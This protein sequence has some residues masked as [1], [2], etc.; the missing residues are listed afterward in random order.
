MRLWEPPYSRQDGSSS[1]TDE[2]VRTYAAKVCNDC[3]LFV[4]EA[5]PAP[6]ARCGM[7]GVSTCH[8]PCPWIV[9][10]PGLPASPPPVSTH[11][12]THTRARAP[13]LCITYRANSCSLVSAQAEADPDAVATAL[14]ILRVSARKKL[15]L[16]SD[17][18]ESSNA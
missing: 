9:R 10:H 1:I 15:T 11:T 17:G 8:A 12:H 18:P 16:P 4:S 6:C 14:E 5:L 2:V 13:Y 3:V 7:C